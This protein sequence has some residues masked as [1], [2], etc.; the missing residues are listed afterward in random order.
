MDV[1]T[2][3]IKVENGEVIKAT[4]S[5]DSMTV[6]GAKTEAATQRLTRRMALLEIEARNMDAAMAKAGQ[7]S[8]K[9]AQGATGLETALRGVAAALALRAFITNTVEAQNA[10]AQLEAAVKSTA[11]VAGRS[12]QQLDDFSMAM[13]RTT[14]YS[15][16]AVKGAQ[17]MLLTFDKIRGQR[18]DQATQA[19][20]DL[21]A[22]MGGDLQ[23]AAVQVGKALQDPE[24]GLTALR[25]SG[26]SFSQSQLDVIKHLYETNQVA[27]G[28]AVILKELEHQFGGS[29]AAARNTL[30]GA[31]AFLKNQWGDLF[32]VTK[33]SSGGIV[34]AIN[35]MGEALPGVRRQ[36]DAFFG[37]IQLAALDARIAYEN[38]VDGITKT[39]WGAIK[40]AIGG[41]IGNSAL[42]MSGGV[43][44]AKNSD[45]AELIAAREKVREQL[46]AQITGTGAATTANNLHAK[47]IRDI[48]APTKEWLAL[49]K[50]IAH[51]R[52]EAI[53]AIDNA[54]AKRLE[55][56]RG[57]QAEEDMQGR[58]L[59]A[60]M[61]GTDAYKAQQDAEEIRNAVRSAGIQ[62]GDEEYTEA[63]RAAK[64]IQDR[65]KE[66]EQLTKAE[67][68]LQDMIAKGVETLKRVAREG[69]EA[70]HKE[71]AKYSA[72]MQ[73]EWLRGIEQITSHG[74]TSFRS[75]FEEVN[76]MF[77]RLLAKMVEAGKASGFGGA[78]LGGASAAIG[79]GLAGYSIGS[80]SASGNRGSAGLFGAAAGAASGAMV[81][82]VVP[83]VGTAIGAA[84]GAVAG[85]VG[86]IIGAGHAADLS[87]HEMDNLRKSL[88]TSIS[89]I[90]AQLSGDTLGSALASLHAQFDAL[91]K[92]A[93]DA[94][95]YG[96]NEAERNRKLAE[97]NALEAQRIQQIKDQDA[98]RLKQLNEDVQVQI[99]RNNGL[100]EEA[101]AMA[102][103]IDQERRFAELRK[104]GI[105]DAT[106][107]LLR[108]S[109]A[110]RD[111]DAAA[112]DAANKL[113]DAAQAA[114]DAAA[115]AKAQQIATE[116]ISVELL[117]AQG[118]AQE[119]SDLA[120]QLA[121]D[122]RAKEALA[123]Y[124][125]DSD[126]VKRL[127]E[128]QQIQRDQRA[129]Q[130]L[131][132]STG[133]SSGALSTATAATT[134][135]SATV[136]D[137]TALMLVDLTRT[138][139]SLLSKIEVNT[140][141]GGAG[142]GRSVH[143]T[144]NF[145]KELTDEDFEAVR[146]RLLDVVNEG[147]GTS[148]LQ[149]TLRSGGVT[150]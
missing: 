81:G 133:G 36:F 43:D 138:E 89:D 4:Q 6:A 65:R 46:A 123:T 97:L 21:A 9:L 7:S 93:E 69:T 8:F 88:A 1:A 126:F 3:A 98:L 14:I 113:K 115:K 64:A 118:K 56:I 49:Q 60:M 45:M 92:A 59:A 108:E 119:A 70:Q 48:I 122:R 124:G 28:Q 10:L 116:D 144:F 25:R 11:G 75:F 125:A 77:S 134:A 147:L 132:D 57:L 71:D 139:V 63:V 121:Q 120:F 58:L 79:G 101:D 84:V 26:V 55:G 76:Q 103:A 143:V 111:A 105:D 146:D 91:R 13:Q 142:G 145:K 19:V 112:L 37:G 30:G 73:K 29:A 50:E 106:L 40:S 33:E 38:L 96:A 140:R 22:R 35:A 66:T 82:S 32:E 95:A 150:R 148:S 5:L 110:K 136:T 68:D 83:V 18:F 137:R 102:K 52:T 27:A 72:D 127:N 107:A 51:I 31:L 117:N 44:M 61:L 78:L 67:E 128:L 15:D 54:R 130:Q 42:A 12:V 23:G 129:A 20:A 16:E 39:P 62:L 41:A 104:Q 2:L 99:L 114:A 109:E 131:I 86:G 149:A 94:Y 53:V 74:L 135:V 100:A 47:S 90:K 87:A 17:A 34:A 85:F 141:D 80:G 24:T